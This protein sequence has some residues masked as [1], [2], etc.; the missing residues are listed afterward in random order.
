MSENRNI[1]SEDYQMDLLL[2]LEDDPMAKDDE[3][4][5][6]L[7]EWCSS[8]KS[9]RKVKFVLEVRDEKELANPEEKVTNLEQ[10][11]EGE[12]PPVQAVWQKRAFCWGCGSWGNM[13]PMS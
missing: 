13:I 2:T 7:N 5:P 8:C 3:F 6:E 9:T 1:N 11:E 12:T 10:I 4:W